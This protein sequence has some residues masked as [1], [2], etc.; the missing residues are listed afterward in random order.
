MPRTTVEDRRATTEELV[1]HRD[2]L[3][4]MAERCHITDLRLRSDGALVVKALS[5][6]YWDV[7]AF[8][9]QGSELV[10]AHV[11]VVTDDTPGAE[12]VAAPL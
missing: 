7:A 1:A 5:P 3:I 4:L 2:D 10:G 11:Y 9:A 12:V 8:V 6:G